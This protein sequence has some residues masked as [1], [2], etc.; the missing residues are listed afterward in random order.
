[1]SL[2]L[3]FCADTSTKENITKRSI[4][5]FLGYRA[6]RKKILDFGDRAMMKLRT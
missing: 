2:K 3:H 1:M 4:K 6:V 5:G